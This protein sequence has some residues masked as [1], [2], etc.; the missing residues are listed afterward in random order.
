[1][2]WEPDDHLV[3]AALLGN[4]KV[5]TLDP[6]DRAWVIA[7]LFREGLTAET[8][9]E[10]CACSL[11]L[12][13]QIK[14]EPITVAFSYVQEQMAEAERQRTAQESKISLLRSKLVQAELDVDR[15]RGRLYGRS[16]T[17]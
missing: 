5:K 13:F 4:V 1:M 14:A 17:R 3:P 9:A 7:G 16:V 6:F 11:R 15:Y 12:V 2:S 10:K 8:I